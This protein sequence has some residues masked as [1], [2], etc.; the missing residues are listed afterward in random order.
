MTTTETEP[1][2]PSLGDQIETT[3]E[4]RFSWRW[5]LLLALSLVNVW[6]VLWFRYLPLM[7]HP[8]HLLQA[9]VLS[10][11][12]SEASGYGRFY[13]VNFLP[14][15]NIL[16]DYLTALLAQVFEIDF[17]ARFMVAAAMVLLPLSVWFYLSRVRPGTEAWAF[18]VVPLSWSRFVAYGNENFTL[19]VP[20]LFFFLGII[21]TKDRPFTKLRFAGIMALATVIYFTHFLIFAVAGLGVTLHWLLGKKSVRS[22][23]EQFVPLVPGCILFL[24]WSANKGATAN[25]GTISAAGG[26]QTKLTAFLQGPNPMPWIE[27]DKSIFWLCLLV[28]VLIFI[29]VGGVIL[30]RKGFR[31]PVLLFATSACIAIA[32]RPWTLIYIPDQRMWYLAFILGLALLPKLGQ[33]GM[34]RVLIFALPLAIGSSINMGMRF[35]PMNKDLTAV[36]G[37]FAQFPPNLRLIYLGEPSL[38][39]HLHR[40]FEYYHVRKGGRS[41]QQFVGNEH[42]VRYA[43][44]EFIVPS[45]DDY[46]V[47]SYTI[48]PWIEHLDRFDGALIIGQPSQASEAIIAGLE[49]HRF[50]RASTGT[51]TL[52]L[53]PNWKPEPAAE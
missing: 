52:M 16:N 32:L 24:I 13:S 53:S 19:G 6:P 42:S 34:T 23:F 8:S 31:L 26:W 33:M 46:S 35:D 27:M 44:G 28:S 47:Y 2:T 14:A 29:G 12:H 10:Q 38:P 50:R 15:P 30:F 22:F 25:S 7:D 49:K 51:I 1:S 18:F 39:P 41:T 20:L 3:S 45:G 9:R 11:L 40:C 43:A 21:A 37:V 5:F 48:D 17:A 36:D 4:A